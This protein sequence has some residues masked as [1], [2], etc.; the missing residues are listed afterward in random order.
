VRGSWDGHVVMDVPVRSSSARW[1]CR[2]SA[3]AKCRKERSGAVGW[4]GKAGRRGWIRARRPIILG[5]QPLAAPGRA[6][7]EGWGPPLGVSEPRARRPPARRRDGDSS[8]RDTQ[9]AHRKARLAAVP[10]PTRPGRT[11]GPRCPSR[12]PARDSP[13]HAP[14]HRARQQPEERQRQGNG[15]D[16]V[17]PPR[18]HLPWADG[19]GGPARDAPEAAHGHQPHLGGLAPFQRPEHLPLPHPLPM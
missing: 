17:Q 18:Q 1:A 19:A 11:S 8:P 10:G 2:A 5:A 12:P 7:V 3:R 16:R 9:A 13:V 6:A 15:W 14:G 4:D